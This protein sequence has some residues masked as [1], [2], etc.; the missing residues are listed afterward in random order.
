LAHDV[1]LNALFDDT[2]PPLDERNPL[3]FL[4]FNL[5]KLDSLPDSSVFKWHALKEVCVFIILIFDFENLLIIAVSIW[6]V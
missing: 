2:L 4:V 1:E 5:L 3:R 6:L